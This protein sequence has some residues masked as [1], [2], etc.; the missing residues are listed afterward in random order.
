MLT[1][2]LKQKQCQIVLMNCYKLLCVMLLVLILQVQLSPLRAVPTA[3][4]LWFVVFVN[5]VGPLC[6]VLPLIH[7]M[8]CW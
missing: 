5:A 3:R 4:L 6:I 8:F 1:V 7:V 2:N